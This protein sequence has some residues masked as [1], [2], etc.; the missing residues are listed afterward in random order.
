[1]EK[2]KYKSV[3]SEVILRYRRAFSLCESF[4]VLPYRWKHQTGLPQVDDSKQ[5]LRLMHAA[6]VFQFP[7]LIF[8]IFRFAESVMSPSWLWSDRIYMIL[9]MGPHSFVIIFFLSARFDRDDVV[10]CCG[11]LIKILRKHG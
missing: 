3:A 2:S 6:G 5:R 9:I 10:A 11:H 7:L 4:R 1:M 8:S